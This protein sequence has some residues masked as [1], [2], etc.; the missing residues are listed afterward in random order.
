MSALSFF[1]HG[2]QNKRGEFLMGFVL[3]NMYFT[4]MFLSSQNNKFSGKIHSPFLKQGVTFDDLTELILIMDQIMKDCHLPKHDERYRY[5]KSHHRMIDKKLE[6]REENIQ[7]NFD[8]YLNESMKCCKESQN[9]F[10]IKVMYRQNYTWQGE[11]IWDEKG[12]KKFFRS[13]LELMHII[14]SVFED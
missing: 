14:Y 1:F 4:V 10:Q 11:I 3:K 2:S 5:F 12:R 9:S 8:A 6:Y 13:A 7:E